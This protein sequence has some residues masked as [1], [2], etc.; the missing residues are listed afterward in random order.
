LR[1]ALPPCSTE[2]ESCL[3]LSKYA[4]VNISATV[5]LLLTLEDFTATELN[6]IL[7]GKIIM[8]IIPLMMDAEMVYETLGFRPQLTRLIARE[9]LVIILLLICRG[10]KLVL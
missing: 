5:M 7:L 1:N 3:L 6:K 10:M 4:D 8:G 9:D 2:I